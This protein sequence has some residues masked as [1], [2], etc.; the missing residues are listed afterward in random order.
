MP[1]SNGFLTK[2]WVR[3]ELIS[4]K[5]I[6]NTNVGFLVSYN[7]FVNKRYIFLHRK[8]LLRQIITFFRVPSRLTVKSVTFQSTLY[9]DMKITSCKVGAY[10]L[11][12]FL[13]T[14]T[15]FELKHQML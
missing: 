15:V 10:N 4:A 14:N 7:S 13:I 2:R 12:H 8:V 5:L 3:F 1:S 9:V 11:P 6:R